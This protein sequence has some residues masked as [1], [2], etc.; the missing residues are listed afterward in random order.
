MI[1]EKERGRM[2]KKGMEMQEAELQQENFALT[3]KTERNQA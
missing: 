2:Q 1:L 3:H